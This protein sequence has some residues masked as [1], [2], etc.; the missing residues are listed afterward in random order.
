MLDTNFML[1]ILPRV[2]RASLV[3]LEISFLSLF[4]SVTLGLI[5]SIIALTSGKL[6]NIIIRCFVEFTRGVPQ[7]VQI[8]IIYF[9]LPYIGIYFD[10]FWTGVVALSFIGA[11]YTIEIFRNAVLNVNKG[12]HEAGKILGL[13]NYQT[14]IYVLY[15]QIIKRSLPPITN[16]LINVVKASALLSVISV[17]ELTKIMN[18]VIFEYFV[19]I[20]VLLEATIMYLL[21]I[22]VLV[23]ISRYFEKRLVV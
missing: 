2:L 3:T 12:Q 19:V 16:E 23:S 4:F 1:E 18:D 7:L 6:I 14:L 10:E 17:N 11:G 8:S 15:P 20:E 13:T 5:F 21:I 22:S 9:A